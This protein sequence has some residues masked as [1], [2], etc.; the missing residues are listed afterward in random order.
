MVTQRASRPSHL[1]YYA[2]ICLVALADRGL[3]HL[4]S[5]G[6]A[7]GLMHY[8]DY[9]PTH[10]A[11]AWWSPGI[12]EE[13]RR[14]VIGTLED[15]LRPFGAVRTRT[16][17]DVIS[18]DLLQEG[19]SVFNIQIANRSAQLR[20][21]TTTPWAEVLLDSLDDLVASK[22]VA[23][24]E[25]GAPRDFRDIFALCNAGLVTPRRCWELWTERQNLTGGD[26]D[27]RRAS[28]A[29]ETH[30][31]RIELQRPLDRV[32]DSTERDDAA[33]LRTWFRE[34]FL[35]AIG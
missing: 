20:P 5:V 7:V 25:R 18:L 33:R 4:I 6:G 29:V 35:D 3:G 14:L 32:C 15:A 8:L 2:E 17:G 30:L 22:M 13:E 24:V 19:R 1:S 12:S 23:L 16:W 27:P 28:V 11:H 34:V 31:E 26:T 21:S 10:D 9:R